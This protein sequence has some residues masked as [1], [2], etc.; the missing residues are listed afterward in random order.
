MLNLKN[1]F[2]NSESEQCS[3]AFNRDSSPKLMIEGSFRHKDFEEV[4][5]KILSLTVKKIGN[6]RKKCLIVPISVPQLHVGLTH[7]SNL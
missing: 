2:W 3:K 1:L 5:M 4:V 7:S 6:A